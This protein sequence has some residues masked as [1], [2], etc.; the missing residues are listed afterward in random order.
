L[1]DLLRTFFIIFTFTQHVYTLP[2]FWVD[3][4]CPLVLCFCWRENIR[5]NKKDT[6]FLLVW[7]KDSYTQRST[8][9]L[10]CTCVSQPSSV[11][12]Y[13]TPSLLPSSFPI[14]ASASLKLLIS[15]H[16]R[17]HI[18]HIQ[19]LGFFSFPYFFCT[20]SLLSVWPMSNNMICC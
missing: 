4:F 12:L 14:V 2:H 15:L 17:E 7:D 19:L 11:H 3:L 18:K 9:L 1:N 13:Q 5:Y 20:C 8:E 6:A 16:Y 10:P